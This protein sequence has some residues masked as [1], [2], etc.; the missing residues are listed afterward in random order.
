M[1]TTS[2]QRAKEILELH[3]E[4]IK[5][6]L[7]NDK[8]CLIGRFGTIECQSLFTTKYSPVL[9]KNAGVFGDQDAWKK[10]YRNSVRGADAL[11]LGW[12]GPTAP[13][14]K[15][16]IEDIDILELHLRALEPYYVDAGNRWTNCLAG[17]K[18]CVVTSFASTAKSQL[19]KREV[20]GAEVESIWP[21]STQWSFVQTG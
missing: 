16:I 8:P 13:L 6:L 11:A 10:A 3:V 18:V 7:Q 17:K 5:S 9:E 12:Y 4:S 1:T 2:T 21:S 19:C 14:E 20:W 15:K